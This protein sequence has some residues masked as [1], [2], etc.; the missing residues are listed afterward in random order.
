MNIT[1][2]NNYTRGSWFGTTKTSFTA[3]NWFAGNTINGGVLKKLQFV[4]GDG[5][6]VKC[7]DSRSTTAPQKSSFKETGF[8]DFLETTTTPATDAEGK[9]SLVHIGAIA[10][11]GSSASIPITRYNNQRYTFQKF[12]FRVLVATPDMTSGDNDLSAFAPIILTE[13]AGISR[14]LA[15]INA[16]TQINNFQELLE[17]LHVLAIGLSGSQSYAGAFGGNLFNYDG[18]VLTT[19]FATVNVDA[20]ASSK[21]AYNSAT[22]T[23]TIKSSVLTS[24]LDVQRW[25]NSAGAV[26]L[27]NGA[28]IEG[29]YQDNSGTSTVLTISGFDANSAVY[30]E[31][32]TET[33]KF[34]SADA[35][36]TV[37]YYIPPT[38]TGSWYY[39]VEKY[40]NQRQSDFFTFS[41]GFLSIVVKAIPDTGLTE[42]TQATVA[43][44]TE[45]ENPDKVYDYVAFLRLSVPHIS[46]GQIVFK[47]GTALD[48]QDADMIIDQSFASVASFNY[49]TKVLTV[50]SSSMVTGT[51]YNLIKTTPPKTIEAASTEVI[52]VN[53][54]DANGDSSVNIQG[55]SGNFTLWKIT[56]ATDEDDYAT[57]TNLGTVTNEIYRFL[58]DPGFKIVIRDNTTGFRQVV[59]MDK[60]N[61]TR[62]LF[63]GDQVQLA[64]S[65]EVSQINTKVDILANDIDGIKGSGFTVNVDSLKNISDNVQALQDVDFA[66]EATSQTILT[67]V[68]T[69]LQAVDYVEPDNVKIANIDD[70][71]SELQNYDDT[72]MQTKLDGL[73]TDLD[74]VA[75]ESTAQSIKTKVDSLSNYNDTT[76]QAKLDAI[77]AKTDTLVNTDLTGIALEATSQEILTAIDNIPATDLGGID[78]DLTIINNKLNDISIFL[79]VDG[80]LPG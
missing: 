32:N 48:L 28:I 62:G 9:I 65:Q 45:L 17:E 7:Y 8:I 24:A 60:G 53:I 39:A 47:D 67:N 43:A 58:S 13:Q 15:T 20:T 52:S 44:Y 23:L 78:A 4:N 74:S 33:E 11:G 1:I 64:Q 73:A 25:N 63:F 51:T 68:G 36:G 38:A 19:S 55:G 10:T 79:P 34:Y 54:E 69:P 14:P 46:Y 21:I 37:T 57:G 75:L 2:L 3:S 61:Y 35:T 56:N 72:V 26:N 77:K 59:P 66:L 27:L 31:D 30:I 5:G 22:N 12:G 16:A 49:D 6:I 80:D 71:V 41:G 29:V 42:L 50:K 40:G 18:A 76:A 70:M